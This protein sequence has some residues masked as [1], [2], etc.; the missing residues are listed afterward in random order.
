MYHCII[1]IISFFSNQNTF[2]YW[3]HKPAMLLASLHLQDTKLILVRV[4]EAIYF[5]SLPN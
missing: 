4:W 3:S 1:Y 5:K 2:Q